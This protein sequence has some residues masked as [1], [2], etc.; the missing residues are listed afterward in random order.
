[1]Q[2]SFKDFINFNKRIGKMIISGDEGFGK[3][4]LLVRIAI[5]KMMNGIL[6]CPK[7]WEIVD[8][9]N[10]YGFSFSK[11]YDHLLFSNFPINCQGTEIPNRE[12]YVVNPFKLGYY[13]ENYETDIFPPYTLMCITEGKIYF[14]AYEWEKFPMRFVSY[15]KTMRQAYLDLVV[16]TQY[17]GDICTPLRRITNRFIYLTKECEPIKDSKGNV[18][19]HKLFV[20][21]WKN[22]RD[23]ELFEK[24]SKKVNCEEYELIIDMCVFDNYDSHFCKFLHLVGRA[25]QDFRIEHFPKI[26]TIEDIENFC[27]EFGYT[28]PENFYKSNKKKKD[29]APLGM[30]SLRDLDKINDRFEDLGF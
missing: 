15:I 30:G 23:V 13:D 8:K 11:N 16:D 20:I 17:F 10:E 25:L 18:V 14:D 2:K 26:R 12:N 7:S 29:I 5:E 24:T 28:P 22:N 9:Y 27:K 1:M 3:T 4:L 6:D 19:G 21:E